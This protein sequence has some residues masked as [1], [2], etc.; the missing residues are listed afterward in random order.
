MLPTTSGGRRVATRR[1]WTGSMVPELS[2]M[3]DDFFGRPL[4]SWSAWTPAADLYETEDAFV[5]EMELPGFDLDDIELTMERGV[6]TVTG[7]R[8]VE[9]TEG[10]T[11][12]LRERSVDRFTRSYALP[13]SVSAEDIDASFAEGVLK[14][15][16]PKAPEAKPRRIEVKAR[17]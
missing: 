2:T 4:S 13:R 10:R 9:E 14:V 8:S 5:L 17:K 1:P 15:T 6:L 3:L 11:Y 16:L 12:H 7:S